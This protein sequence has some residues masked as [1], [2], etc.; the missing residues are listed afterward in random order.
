MKNPRTLPQPEHR[1]ETVTVQVGTFH[2]THVDI[3]FRIDATV[4]AEPNRSAR[5]TASALRRGTATLPGV[6]GVVYARP[7]AVEL[8]DQYGSRVFTV[9]SPRS[10]LA[11][12]PHSG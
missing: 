2:G 6:G 7:T 10:T 12:N 8:S 11:P 3:T 1:T 5:R 4:W 9:P